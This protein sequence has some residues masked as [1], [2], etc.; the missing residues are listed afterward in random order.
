MIVNW[1]IQIPKIIS[2]IKYFEQIIRRIFIITQFYGI[3]ALKQ[4]YFLKSPM[5]CF[6]EPMAQK[7]RYD[8]L[9]STRDLW[10]LKPTIFVF[11]KNKLKI[12]DLLVRKHVTSVCIDR[13]E[14]EFF[15]KTIYKINIFTRKNELFYFLLNF[16]LVYKFYY[17]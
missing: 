11:W 4:A 3:P 17:K 14:F 13:Y 7:N 12:R 16:A 2:K 8:S 10:P 15:I 5:S 9:Y 1:I 6:L